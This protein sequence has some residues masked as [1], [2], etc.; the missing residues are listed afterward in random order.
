MEATEDIEGGHLLGALNAKANMTV[1]VTNGHESLEMSTL[2]GKSLLLYRHDLEDLVLEGGTEEQVDD[3]EFFDGQ[4]EKIDLFKTFPPFKGMVTSM[5]RS[6]MLESRNTE[7]TG[8][9][10]K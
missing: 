8:L 1:V 9:L 7:S 5:R 3:L 10:P 4:R 2:T 6:P